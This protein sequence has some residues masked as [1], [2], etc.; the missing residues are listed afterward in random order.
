M[1]KEYLFVISG[2]FNPLHLGHLNYIKYLEKKYPNSDIVFEM[3]ESHC[4]KDGVPSVESR[5]P[6]FH[7]INRPCIITPYSTFMEKIEFLR[8]NNE[9]RAISNGEDIYYKEIIFCMG[10]DTFSRFID[11]K[12]YFGSE[13][14]MKRVID[15][16]T[17]SNR[18]FEI[19]GIYLFPRY[20]TKM[21]KGRD[22]WS[23]SDYHFD[24]AI[25]YGL[26]ILTP[27]L[28]YQ[29]INISSTELR[30]QNVHN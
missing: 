21:L 16:F 9:W 10:E 20:P 15:S 12:S 6:Q 3:G 28:D 17:N 19:G 26:S 4:D 24:N 2:T 7:R 29:P 25:R 1:I 5:F 11:I 13:Y 18:E 14:E 30:G 8:G 27:T 22:K 23:M